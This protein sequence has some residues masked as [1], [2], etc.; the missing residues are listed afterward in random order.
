VQPDLVVAPGVVLPGFSL[1]VTFSR[2]GGP[3]GQNVNKVSS[4]VTLAFDV[5]G[6]GSLTASQKERL[7]RLAGRRLA[8]DGVL[9]LVSQATRD[10]A[11]NLE[12]A[13]ERLKALVL[14]A[15]PEP[16]VRR[17]TKVSRAAKRKRLQAKRRRGDLKKGRRLS[18]KDLGD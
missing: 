4:R 13:R 14:A 10:Q 12:D 8:K 3:G 16:V 7:A 11:R 15:L 1:G 18:A 2:S 5:V 6:S 17:P 9:R